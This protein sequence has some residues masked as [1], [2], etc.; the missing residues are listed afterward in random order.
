[1]Q[2]AVVGAGTMGIG[3]AHAFTTTGSRVTLVE[4]NDVARG[5]APARIAEVIDRS[6]ERGK[7]RPDAA[8]TAKGNLR[9]VESVESIPDNLDIAVEATPEIFDAK[10]AVLRAIEGRSPRI[11][12]SNTSSMSIDRLARNL[13]A[14][15]RV[16]G[17]HF[18]NPVWSM[19][20]VEIVVG[21]A[22]GSAVVAATQECVVALGKEFITVRDSPGFATSRLGIV[23]GLEAIRMVEEGV[24]TPEDID[25]GMVIGY[26]HPMGPLRL[27]DLVGLDIRLD[28]AHYLAETLGDRFKPPALLEGM[29]ASGMLG[30]KSG[31]GFYQW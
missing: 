7:L 18:F 20:L 3:I 11:L 31:Q 27:G 13:E 6:V 29:V 2:A 10:V 21:S 15:D 8:H 1:M 26:G 28:I 24:A 25:K 23:A 4:T 30:K 5:N 16:I 19:A 9:V 17:M 12:A 22:T 14:P